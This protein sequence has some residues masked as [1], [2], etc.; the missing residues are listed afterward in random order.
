MR[1]F[2]KWLTPPVLGA[3]FLFAVFA[4]Q[5]C[6]S[7]KPDYVTGAYVHQSQP[8]V[9]HGPP[10]IGNDERT[11]ETNL[12]GL[13]VAVGWERGLLFYEAGGTY[14]VHKTNVEGGQWMT[15]IKLG[16]KVRP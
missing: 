15:T 14:M 7:V 2:L 13:E 16:V 9:G 6:T 10:P 8:F 1:T 3:L 4:L 11:Q 12:D 5:G